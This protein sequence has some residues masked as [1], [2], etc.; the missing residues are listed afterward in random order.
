[1]ATSAPRLLEREAALTALREAHARAQATG[2]LALVYGEAGIG[3]TTL[4][5]SFTDSL[6]DRAPVAYGRCDALFTPR[7]LGPAHDIAAHLGGELRAAL[8][9]DK[10]RAAIFAAFLKAL[11]APGTP[12]VVFEDVHWA[13]EATLDLIKFLGRRIGDTRALLVLTYRDDEIGPRHALRLLLGELPR[14][15]VVRVALEPLSL[16]AIEKLVTPDAARSLVTPDAA[17]RQRSG[18]Q[19]PTRIH[20]ATGGNPFYVTE[21]LAS[22]SGVSASVRDAVLARAARLGPQARAA[23]DLVSVSPGGLEASIVEACIEGGLEAVAECEERGI[24]RPLGGMLRFRHEIARLA[25]LDALPEGRARALNAQVL[26]AL[27]SR[28]AGGDDLARLAHHAQAAGE[29]EAAY[30]Y[31]TAAARR[32]AALGAHREAAEHYALAARF[33]AHVDERERATLHDDFAWECHLTGRPEAID[34]RRTAI[35][36][37]RSLGDDAKA[38]ESLARFSHWLVALG[39]DAESEVAMRE[40]LDLIEKQPVGPAHAVVYRLHAYLRML[41]RDVDVAIEDGRKALSLAERFGTAEDR[42]NILNTIGSAMLVSDDP[43]GVTHLER[44]LEIARAESIDYHV[45]NAYGNLGSAS[46]EVHRFRDALRWLDL[47]IAWARSHDLDNSCLYQLSWRSLT[48]LFLGRWTEVGEAADAVLGNPRVTPIA[49]IMAL[50]AVGRLRARRGDP[51]AWSALD[52]ALALSE[53]TQT[54]QRLAPTRAARAE[55]AWLAGE[56]AA[57]AREAAACDE[58]ARRKRHAWFVGELAY[59]QWKGGRAVDV[60]D[61]AAR[62]YAL[63]MAGRWKEAAEDWAERGCPYEQARALAEG[64]TEGKLA[65]LRMFDDLG[66][67]PAADRVRQSLRASGV[68]RIP[69][70]PR[71]STRAQPAGLTARED[72]ILGLIAAGLTN[73]EIGARLHIS[74]KTVDH[75]VS[76]LLAKLGVASRREAAKAAK[77][78]NWVGSPDVVKG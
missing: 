5:S 11:K 13:D 52:E 26:A 47:G 68:R 16:A 72:Q 41:E 22:G 46:G 64:D 60:P 63:Q 71:A 4:V 30:D 20:E 43:E 45:S 59:W 14:E 18:A 56:D 76:A 61:Y 55:A 70:G 50:L 27:R 35:A 3:K 25:L 19:L 15:R 31:A 48:L 73:T 49:R 1:M 54:L 42:S 51:G 69:R 17:A 37:W 66:A 57:A 38:A 75:H 65:A 10:S 34:A 74:P 53:G 23:A 67:R 6:G 29:A 33:S 24:L 21:I 39:R 8:D 12:V 32:A 7:V 40:A 2:G 78:L 9:A 58:L 62:P 44:G 77:A 28:P 36:L